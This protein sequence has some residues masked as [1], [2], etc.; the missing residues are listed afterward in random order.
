MTTI[1]ALSELVEGG[2]D[3]VGAVLLDN[4][5]KTEAEFQLGIQLEVRQIDITT[6]TNLDITIERL[7]PE[8]FV[9]TGREVDSGIKTG[10]EVRTEIVITR[11][12][13]LYVD[14]NRQI[15]A[16][17]VLRGIA[18]AD[19]LVESYMLLAKMD[20]GCHTKGKMII[21]AHL[22]QDTNGKAG[23]II[24][25]LGIPLLS[26]G[27]Y[28]PIVVQLQILHVESEEESIV[29]LAHIQVRAVHHLTRLS[30]HCPEAAECQQSKN[31]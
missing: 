8:C 24:I 29:Q 4:V 31:K 16:F 12:G 1:Y 27:C 2:V 15:T 18:L 25:Y 26:L 30:H 28:K 9:L 20:G 13:K 5:Q 19:L 11:S 14:G 6:H 7:Q 23:G 10:N 3:K 17:D 21:Q 22:A